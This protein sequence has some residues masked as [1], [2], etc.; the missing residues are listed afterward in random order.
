MKNT[1]I[2]VGATD[3]FIVP[4]GRLECQWIFELAAAGHVLTTTLRVT[5]LQPTACSAQILH[6]SQALHRRSSDS[7]GVHGLGLCIFMKPPSVCMGAEYSNGIE[8]PAGS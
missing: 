2:K 1:V 6:V 3:E 5:F 7:T 4:L 8:D